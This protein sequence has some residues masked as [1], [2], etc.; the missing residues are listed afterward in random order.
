MGLPMRI[1]TGAAYALLR[2]LTG[3]SGYGRTQD[4]L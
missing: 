4:F 1:A 2:V 3:I